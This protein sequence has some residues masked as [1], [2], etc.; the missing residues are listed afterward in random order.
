MWPLP[1]CID[2]MNIASNYKILCFLLSGTLYMKK[3]CLRERS[4]LDLKGG[5]CDLHFCRFRKLVSSLLPG[6]VGFKEL[7]FPFTYSEETDLNQMATVF[8]HSGATPLWCPGASCLSGIRYSHNHMNWDCLINSE[9]TKIKL[10]SD[11]GVFFSAYRNWH[12]SNM[13]P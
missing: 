1:S 2:W 12:Y 10:S 13:P 9:S 5:C 4:K 3:R 6:I 11:Q 8:I 7:N